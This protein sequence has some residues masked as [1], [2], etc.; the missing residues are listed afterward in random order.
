D[1]S[2]SIVSGRCV[3]QIHLHIAELEKLHY[4]RDNLG[5]GNIYVTGQSANFMVKAKADII[6]LI[7]LFNGQLF[8]EKKQ[9]QFA[10]WVSAYNLKYGT[11]LTA[12]PTRLNHEPRV[13]LDGLWPVATTSSSSST[14]TTTSSPPAT[15]SCVWGCMRFVPVFF[16]IVFSVFSINIFSFFFRFFFF[17]LF[18]FFSFFIN[19]IYYFVILFFFYH[20]FISRFL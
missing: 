2:F 3:F 20:F 19:K 10:D 9:A 16:Y 13:F 6:T 17:F 14:T 5:F 1:G 15:L 12:R 11:N 4:I 7:N 18:L 8:L